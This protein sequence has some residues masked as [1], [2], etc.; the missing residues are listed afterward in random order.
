M[1]R[2]ASRLALAGALVFSLAWRTAG[3]PTLVYTT[4]CR[5]SPDTAA[6]AVRVV[7]QVLT[8]NDSA[9]LVE[10]GLPFRPTQNAV[11]SDSATCQAAINAHNAQLSGADTLLRVESGYVVSASGAYGLFLPATSSPQ[12]SPEVSLFTSLMQYRFTQAMPY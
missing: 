8:A 1:A 4:P 6:F 2:T 10:A 7:V 11:V 3:R 12:R 9:S 5:T